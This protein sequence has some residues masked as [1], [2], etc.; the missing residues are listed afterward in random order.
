LI[1]QEIV[2]PSTNISISIFELSSPPC[3]FPQIWIKLSECV[4]PTFIQKFLETYPLFG[5]ESGLLIDIGCNM[6]INLLMTYIKIT[7]NYDSF[8][9][10]V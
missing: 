2:Q 5:S 3:V 6:D 8:T 10:A 9:F 7:T 4:N 1:Y